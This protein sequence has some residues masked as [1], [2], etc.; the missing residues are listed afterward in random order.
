MSG[1][2][3]YRRP[4]T[5]KDYCMQK[6]GLKNKW[7]RVFIC[8]PVPTSEEKIEKVKD[9]CRYAVS[10]ECIPIEPFQYI[11]EYLNRLE[12]DQEEAVM[13]FAM[14]ELSTCSEAWVIGSVLTHEMQDALYW[15]GRWNVPLVYFDD[16]DDGDEEEKNDE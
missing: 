13:E 5:Y 9:Y 10:R 14:Q 16:F 11:E 8:C 3:S 6:Y 15:A 1:F 4:V 7:R 2:A 12:L